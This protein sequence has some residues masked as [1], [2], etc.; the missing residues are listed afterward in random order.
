MSLSTVGTILLPTDFSEGAA[1]AFAHGLK[2]ALAL[3]AEL[4]V[5][6]VEPDNDQT[7]WHWAPSVLKTL[8]RWGTV[9]ADADEA[10][11]QALGIR[12]RRSSVGGVK[13]DEA[14]LAEMVSAHADLVVMATHG[15]SGLV[16][17]TQPS[18]A[19]GVAAKGSA[20]M[21]L[22]PA[23]GKG[24]VDA[25]TGE[26]SL[27]K[28]L[29]A[30]DHAPDP[31]FGVEAA[32]QIAEL[33]GGEDLRFGTVHVGGDFP[34]AKTLFGLEGPGAEHKEIPSGDVVEGILGAAAGWD[35]DLV[36]I[37]TAGRS[38][39]LDAVR[40]STVERLI[41]RTDRPLLVI[42]DRKKSA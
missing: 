37:V 18:V 5:F 8:Q 28:V 7:D 26:S 32:R 3:R 12:A 1:V 17:W 40:G 33:V 41:A 25:A 2:L 21:L 16:R 13:A 4:D 29:I 14:I 30:V 22:L 31:R 24:F 35:A 19:A 27:S 23:S 36:V 9:A 15:R 39:L 42:P 11:V 6:H 20:P 34:A 10:A 38:G